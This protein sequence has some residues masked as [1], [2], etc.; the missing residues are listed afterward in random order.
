MKKVKFGEY[1]YNYE[2]IDIFFNISEGRIL[3][4]EGRFNTEDEGK[5]NF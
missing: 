4:E 1:I 5:K 2:I 3:L